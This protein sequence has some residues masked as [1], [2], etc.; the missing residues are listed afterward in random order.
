MSNEQTMIQNN[1]NNINGTMMIKSFQSLP[2]PSISSPHF[3][4]YTNNIDIKQPKNINYYKNEGDESFFFPSTSLSMM[5]T[6]NESED[7]IIIH[8]YDP[9]LSINSFTSPSPLSSINSLSNIKSHSHSSEHNE[10]LSRDPEFP[11][12]EHPSLHPKYTNETSRSSIVTVSARSSGNSAILHPYTSNHGSN[13]NHI[14]SK[15]NLP[16][17][18]VMKSKSNHHSLSSKLIYENM[19]KYQSQPPAQN[20]ISNGLNESFAMIEDDEDDNEEFGE[21]LP[22]DNNEEE[23]E[24]EYYPTETEFV[25]DDEALFGDDD[26]AISPLS[27]MIQPPTLEMDYNLRDNLL[28]TEQ[29]QLSQETQCHEIEYDEDGDHTTSIPVEFRKLQ[30]SQSFNN[31]NNAFDYGMFIFIP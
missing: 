25:S 6:I 1:I 5:D 15:E 8:E 13:N 14:W 18:N 29:G 19:D 28:T 2:S 12:D 11:T 20:T 22:F 7:K 23:E 4:Q 21:V 17:I 10:I 3:N 9:K 30:L 26:G 24:E 31:D 16:K 27:V